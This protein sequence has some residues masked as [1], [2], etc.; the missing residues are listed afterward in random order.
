M[1][2]DRGAVIVGAQLYEL[3]LSLADRLYPPRVLLSPLADA[4]FPEVPEQGWH[5]A[6]AIEHAADVETPGLRFGSVSNRL[7]Q[8]RAAVS[9]RT[10]DP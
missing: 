1:G 8:C 9:A 5:L 10:M 7:L 4:F 2:A 3:G 6:S